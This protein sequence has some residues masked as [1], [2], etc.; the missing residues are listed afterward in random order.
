MKIGYTYAVCKKGKHGI[1]QHNIYSYKDKECLTLICLECHR[2]NKKK[3]YSDPEKRKHDL[4][5]GRNWSKHNPEK[6]EKQKQNIKLREEKQKSDQKFKI[7]T[8]LSDKS[9]EINN[10]LNKIESKL[11]IKDVE[12]YCVRH[13]TSSIW[14]VR[15]FI[16][17]NKRTEL[18]RWEQLKHSS[19]VKYEWKARK[20]YSTLPESVKIEIRKEYM[21]RAK[22]E[23]NK[24]IKSLCKNLNFAD[25]TIQKYLK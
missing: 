19:Y 25:S 23:V 2:E 8:E 20:N 13:N 7:L 21:K 17:S 24:Q 18:L 4:E 9:V 14:D 12:K 10:I 3:R 16:I 1:T 11:T 15:N 5:Y 6:V 22:D